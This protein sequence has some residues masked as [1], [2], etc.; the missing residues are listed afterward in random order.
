MS[1]E[2]S[3][4]KEEYLSLRKEVENALADLSSLERNCV[5]AMSA[6]Y[7]WLISKDSLVGLDRQLGW[8][9][10]ILLSVFGALR[11][12]SINRHLG[13]IGTYII[14]I[15]QLNNPRCECGSGACL[16]HSL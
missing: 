2:F 7:A 14:K 8:G 5:L 4:Q 10:P 12:Y 11:C 3:H 16:L 6:V 13:T 9:I 1:N 15:E